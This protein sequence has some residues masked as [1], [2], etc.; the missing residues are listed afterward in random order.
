MS[1]HDQDVTKVY[2]QAETEIE[3]AVFISAPEYLGLPPDNVLQVVKPL[4][5]IPASGFHWYLTYLQHHIELLWITK[6]A[7]DPFLL[8]KRS[9]ESLDGIVVIQ[10]YY[11]LFFGDQDFLG[12]EEDGAKKFKSNP[13][14]ILTET[15]TV[16]NGIRIRKMGDEIVSVNQQDKIDS[17][18]VSETE[19][20]FAI[21]RA[22][23]QYV[24]F[25]CRPDVYT[26]LPQIAPVSEATT[27]E[28]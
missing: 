22:K 26:V 14:V 10:V 18:R 28:E 6:V 12:S 17:L 25:N 5:S 24:S 4:Y 8:I 9:K 19:K 27:K 2:V 21:E 7:V 16:F 11:S 13:R 15:S 23:A 20:T 1:T 3:R